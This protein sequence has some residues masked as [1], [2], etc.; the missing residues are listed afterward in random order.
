MSPN[1]ITDWVLSALD[2]ARE[3]LGTDQA[4]AEHLNMPKQNL[5]AVRTG[6][7][8][9]FQDKDRM[10]VLDYLAH[11]RKLGWSMYYIM[12]ADLLLPVP[13]FPVIA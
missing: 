12:Q 5:S 10:G 6:H 3:M 1:T 7:R 4:V 11:A 9:G 13:F 2:K 8:A